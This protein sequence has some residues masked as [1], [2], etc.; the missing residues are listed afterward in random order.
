[1]TDPHLEHSIFGGHEDAHEA[2]ASRRS[3][4]GPTGVARPARRSAGAA[5]SGA[6]SS[7][8]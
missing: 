5:G 7:P 2:A 6:C 1:M 4:A 3:A 8:W